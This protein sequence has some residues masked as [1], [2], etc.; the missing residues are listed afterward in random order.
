MKRNNSQWLKFQFNTIQF[1]TTIKK[2]LDLYAFNNIASRYTKQKIDK[3]TLEHL[4]NSHP[5]PTSATAPLAWKTLECPNPCQLQLQPS[6]Q[7]VHCTEHAR[8]PQPM[9]D[10]APSI[11][12]GQLWCRV[13]Q[14]HQPIPATDPA[15]SPKPPGTRHMQSTQSTFSYKAIP[16]RQGK[17][18]VPPN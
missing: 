5:T 14:N 6:C 17:V 11:P 3:M 8:N 18:A 1:N 9:P 4:R 13:P 16:S 10:S 2:S 15:S 12:V 7:G